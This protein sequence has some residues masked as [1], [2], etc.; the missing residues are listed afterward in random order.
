MVLLNREVI[1]AIHEINMDVELGN[2][3]FLSSNPR[4][5]LRVRL[6]RFTRAISPTLLLFAG[7]EDLDVKVQA[8]LAELRARTLELERDNSRLATDL[9]EARSQ[10]SAGDFLGRE[11]LRGN[12]E[13]VLPELRAALT[14]AFPGQVVDPVNT[15]TISTPLDTDGFPYTTE[16]IFGLS[17]GAGQRVTTYTINIRADREGRWQLP[18][19][20]AYATGAATQSA[21][22]ADQP[23]TTRTTGDLGATR[24]IEWDSGNPTSQPLDPAAAGAAPAAASQSGPLPA[25][26]SRV[27]RFD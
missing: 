21:A 24:V 26:D 13:G 27:I 8:E 3:N 18:E 10:V 22:G 14:R 15:G 2:G 1:F 7:C 20:G 9:R 16:V 19:L 12:L 11:V 17:G 4:S 6:L 5:M 23:E 25:Q